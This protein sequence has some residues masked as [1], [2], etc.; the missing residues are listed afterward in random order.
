MGFSKEEIRAAKRGDHMISW[1]PGQQPERVRAAQVDGDKVRVEVVDGPNA[2][3]TVWLNGAA[4]ECL[5]KG[6]Y[7][8]A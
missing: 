5:I 4:S 6:S 7:R 2:G 8:T 1:A 3:S